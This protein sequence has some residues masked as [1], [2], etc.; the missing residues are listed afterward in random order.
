LIFDVYL[1]GLTMNKEFITHGRISHVIHQ[2]IISTVIH[3]FID[4]CK[5]NIYYKDSDSDII[6]KLLRAGCTYINGKIPK[7]IFETIIDGLIEISCRK[8]NTF[9]QELGISK[10][11]LI[12]QN[13]EWPVWGVLFD[14]GI[15]YNSI[16][17]TIIWSENFCYSLYDFL[18]V[19]DNIN[20]LLLANNDWSRLS[21]II[22]VSNYISIEMSRQIHQI[23][24]YKMPEYNDFKNFIL[25][26]DTHPWI[27]G[28]H[29][30]R[31]GNFGDKLREHYAGNDS[32]TRMIDKLESTHPYHTRQIFLRTINKMNPNDTK[33]LIKMFDCDSNTR[34]KQCSLNTSYKDTNPKDEYYKNKYLKYKAKYLE[35]KKKNKKK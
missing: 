28:A 27:I 5:S 29:F 25:K 22:H 13:G 9:G 3:Q 1:T 35:A 7:K 8:L 19:P 31:S 32:S 30:L 26:Q 18:C 6:N 14:T 24:K 17:K 34:D 15:R 33:K 16:K 10:D 4:D 20:L 11:K 23:I 12:G 2:I 21:Y